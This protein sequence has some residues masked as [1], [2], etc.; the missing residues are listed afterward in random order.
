MTLLSDAARHV[1]PVDAGAPL[2]NLAAGV[3]DKAG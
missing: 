1:V 3:T 2:A